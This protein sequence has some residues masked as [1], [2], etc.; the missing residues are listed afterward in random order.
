MA[1]PKRKAVEAVQV[2]SLDDPSLFINRELSLLGFQRR[3]LEEAND[4]SNPLL[5]R[6]KFLSIL[7]SNLDEFFMV[8]VAGLKQQ[9]EAGLEDPGPDGLS[10]AAQLDSIRPAVAQLMVD[11]RRCFREELIPALAAEGIQLVS[12]HQLDALTRERLHEYFLE[13]VY[14]VLTPL[15]FDPGRPFPH[16]SNLSL[17]LA[18]LIRGADGQEHFARLKVPDTLPQLIPI[19]AYGK[20]RRVKPKEQRF[21]WLDHL[22]VSHL[23]ELFPGMEIIEAHPFHVTRDADIAIQELEADDLLETIEESVRARRFGDV[24]RVK[25]NQGMPDQLLEILVSNLEADWKD[26]YRVEDPISM[27]RLKHLLQIDRRDLRERSFIPRIP[28]SLDP[29]LNE[30][31]DIFSVI[32]RGDLLLHHPFDSFDPVVEFLRKAA[33]DPAVLAIKMT[34]YRVGPNSPVVDCLLEA[35]ENGKQVAVLVE[36][37]ARFD[38][39]SNIEWARRLEAEGVHVV[40]GLLGLKIHSKVALVVR[41]EGDKIRRYTHFGTGNYNVVTAGLYTDLSLMTASEELGA[42]ATDLFNH[43]TGYSAKKHYRKLLVAPVDLLE[44][45][46]SLIHREIEHQRAGRGGHII[47]KMNSLA[48]QEIIALLYEASQAGVKIE[49]IIRG[50]C[51]LRPGVPGVSENISVRSIVGRFL[52]HSRIYW[53]RNGGEADCYL[54]SADMMP[55]NLHRRV[56]ILVP[57][58]DRKLGKQIR[59]DILELYLRDEAK[60]RIMQRDGSYLRSPKRNDPA[61]VNS[62]ARFLAR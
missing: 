54:G 58:T 41:K 42:D 43:L 18:I 13:K 36:L 14:P 33:R 11:A 15:A 29:K 44:R 35:N 57:I 50:A 10:A 59:E 23:G 49:L 19:E 40:Y 34:L 21:I 9:V 45:M 31:S 3:V 26:V 46:K 39:E 48:H 37:K 16:I 27:V 12:L 60:V 55:R 6:V 38:E 30:D 24:V 8:R 56:E 17:N 1:H 25:V 52:E 61:A 47:F 53:F 2:P 28:A 5:D 20:L 32:R 4:P 22:I 51:S 62:Q 7:G